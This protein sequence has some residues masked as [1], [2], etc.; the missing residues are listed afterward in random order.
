M[1]IYSNHQ[2]RLIKINKL[3][4]L[5]PNSIDIS[6]IVNTII[7]GSST[8]KQIILLFYELKKIICNFKYY[9]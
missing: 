3:N 4:I 1:L 7:R 8:L 5:S 6:I 9:I 2:G